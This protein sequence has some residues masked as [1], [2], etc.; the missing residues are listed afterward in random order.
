MVSRFRPSA[1]HFGS[2]VE[3]VSTHTRHNDRAFNF[4]T[5]TSHE[6]TIAFGCHVSVILA[7]IGQEDWVL[8]TGR[9]NRCTSVA[10]L[11]HRSL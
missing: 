5:R 11:R 2:A 9:P 6:L 7:G 1:E 10:R 4:R 3:R 8:G